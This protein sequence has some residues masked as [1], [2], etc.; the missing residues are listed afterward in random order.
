MSKILLSD[1]H[2]ALAPSK[3]L[4]QISNLI[5]I[6]TQTNNTIFEVKVYSQNVSCSYRVPSELILIILKFPNFAFSMRMNVL[7][8][9]EQ[10][11]WSVIAVLRKI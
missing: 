2:S 4:V 10:F 3:M 8:V 11:F 5:N 1:L 7:A 6:S 9:M